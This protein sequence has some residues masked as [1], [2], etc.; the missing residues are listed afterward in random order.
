MM[1][2]GMRINRGNVSTRRK[3]ALVPLCPPQNQHNL[4]WDRTGASAVRSRQLTAWSMARP[5]TRFYLIFL[6]RGV[7]TRFLKLWSSYAQEQACVSGREYWLQ[8]WYDGHGETGTANVGNKHMILSAVSR[9][10]WNLQYGSSPLA[11]SSPI[12]ESGTGGSWD[13]KDVIQNTKLLASA[14]IKPGFPALSI[15][16]II[17]YVGQATRRKM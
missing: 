12:K 13:G 6:K 2:N 1:L 16:K 4:T 9:T 14:R 5:D 3:P 17:L 7:L 15:R 8:Q 11:S 10:R